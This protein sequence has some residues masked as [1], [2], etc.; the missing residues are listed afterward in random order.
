MIE[1]NI[2]YSQ[3]ELRVL[4]HVADIPQ[5]MKAF[6]C[7]LDIHAKKASEMFGVPIVGMDPTLRRRA[8]AIN[9]GTIYGILS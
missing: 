3:I 8:K 4:A 1:K 6:A 5:L 9:F 2:D 7:G